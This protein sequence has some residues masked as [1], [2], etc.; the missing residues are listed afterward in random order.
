MVQT[1]SGHLIMIQL[2]RVRSDIRLMSDFRTS[3]GVIN[4]YLQEHRDGNLMVNSN[5]SWV[6]VPD[7]EAGLLPPKVAAQS[8]PC[9]IAMHNNCPCAPARFGT[10]STHS[11]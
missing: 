9:D 6:T 11:Q 1:I 3:C 8:L 10:A 5:G 4:S 2:A 7:S